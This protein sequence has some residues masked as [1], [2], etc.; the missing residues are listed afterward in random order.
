VGKSD[1]D[2]GDGSPGTLD[3]GDV[4]VY[5]CSHKTAEPDQ[6]CVITALG[7]TATVTG[8]SGDDAAS[9]HWSITTTL[10]CPDLPPDP[11]IPPEPKPE[12]EPGPGP[13]PQ[14]NPE[15]L[16]PAPQ[17]PTTPP[18]PTPP[19]AGAAGVAGI[20][21][22]A[23]AACISHASQIQLTGTRM[24]EFT[25]FVD[26]RRLR[27]QT[28]EILQRRATPLTR[29]F[30]PGRHLLAIRVTFERGSATAPVTLTRTIV[31]C[32]PRAQARPRVTG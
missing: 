6:D 5:G 31:I 8:G 4:W 2:G 20:S 11:P 10:N 7:N 18:V 32:G 27:Q 24:Q 22:R 16:P 19:T 28:V 30:S 23:P 15:P 17:T 26:G 1:G 14:P 25:V 12:P 9:D 13:A 3:P 21:Q 29:V